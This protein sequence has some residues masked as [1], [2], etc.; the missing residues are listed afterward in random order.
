MKQALFF[1]LAL[2]PVLTAQGTASSPTPVPAGSITAIVSPQGTAAMQQATG[3]SSKTSSL[4]R[5]DVCNGDV[6]SD[7][8]VSSS[9]LV[10]A[11]ILKEK[12]A[13]YSAD[14]VK[15]VLL[16]LQQKDV[17]TRAQKI[18]SAGGNVVVLLGALFK[19]VSPTVAASVSA[20]PQVAA[21][22]LPAVTSQYDLAALASKILADNDALALGRAGSG[23]DCHTGLVVAMTPT[24]AIDSVVVQ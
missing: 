17:Y 3:Y 12:T 9:R 1:M 20:A 5:I 18:I 23:N 16:V 11:V 7:H 13:V 4:M 14:V 8:N 2:A 15:A 6:A 19:T 22:I 21:A 10:G 24:V